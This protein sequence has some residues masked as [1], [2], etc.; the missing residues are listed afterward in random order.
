MQRGL[1]ATSRFWVLAGLWD[2]RGLIPMRHCCLRL[3]YFCSA[4]KIKRLEM[5]GVLLVVAGIALLLLAR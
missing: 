1:R 3:R 2:R 4:K 5:S